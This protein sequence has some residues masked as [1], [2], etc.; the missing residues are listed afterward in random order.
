M[1]QDVE[2]Q[3]DGHRL[4]VALVKRS[5]LSAQEV[6]QHQAARLELSVIDAE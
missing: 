6:L 4:R 5:E 1:K 2:W 3:A